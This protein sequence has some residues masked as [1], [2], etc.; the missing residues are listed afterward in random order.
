MKCKRCGQEFDGYAPM[1]NAAY[2]NDIVRYACP[3]CGKL[4]EFR[5]VI[6]VIPISDEDVCLYKDNWGN[7]IVKDEDYGN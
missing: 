7:K 5:R 3:H 6:K 4:H 1:M 2:Y